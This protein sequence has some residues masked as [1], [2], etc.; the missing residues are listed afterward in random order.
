[1]A[2]LTYHNDEPYNREAETISFD[3]PNDMNINE[4]KIV[5]VRLAHAMGYH[6]K[7]I[8]RCFGD[9]EHETESDRE[10]KQFMK[11]VLHLTGSLQL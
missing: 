11:G 4:F 6:Y 7:S 1:M 3:I 2:K 8:E 10:F 9:L 5:C